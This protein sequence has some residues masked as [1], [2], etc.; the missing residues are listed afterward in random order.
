[1]REAEST[2]RERIADRLRAGAASAGAIADEFDVTAADALDH[3]RHVARS[4]EPTDERLLVAPPE[5]R[6]CGFSGF[7]DPVNRP[8]RCPECKAESVRE[9]RFRIE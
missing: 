4:L 9:P 7:D 3:V 6:E 8:S 2:T 1:M 5:C